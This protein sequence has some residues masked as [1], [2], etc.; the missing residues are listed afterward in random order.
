MNNNMNN[1]TELENEIRSHFIFHIIV[2]HSFPEFGIGIKNELPWNIKDELLH[3]KNVTS[4]NYY[5]TEERDTRSSLQEL[6]NILVFG[7]KTWE[8]I[9]EQGKKSI[10]KDRFVIVISSNINNHGNTSEYEIWSTW[11]DLITTLSY[12][13][14][15][16]KCSKHV[17]FAGGRTIYEQSI[18]NFPMSC[19]HITEIYMNKCSK[20][21]VFD[22]F[23]PYYNPFNLVIHNSYKLQVTNC[24]SFIC[25]NNIQTDKKIWYRYK[26]YASPYFI[27]Q[28]LHCINIPLYKV[29]EN[30]YLQIMREIMNDGID[31]N[32][33]TGTGTRAIFSSRQVYDLNDTFPIITTRRQWLKG[34]FEELK[35][36]I[37]GKTDN[38]ILQNK[39]IHIWDGNTSREFLDKRGLC[40]YPEGDMGET[41]GFNF[42]HFGGEYIDCNTNY[43]IGKYGYDQLQNVIHL[44]KYD[45]TSRRIIINLWNPS[46]LH[47][48]SLPSCLM[49]YQ[50][51]VDTQE[52]TL[53]CQ[54]YIRSSDYFLANNWNCCTGALLVHMLCALEDIPYTPGRI[55][56]IT[57]DTHIYKTHFE[58]VYENL[59]RVPVPFP[60][61]VINSDK[62]YSSINDIQYEDLWLIGYQS[63]P[64]ITAPMAI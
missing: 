21:D 48:A 56:V 32:D 5:S 11:D 33:R 40:H 58:Q 29:E 4:Y 6:R 64:S 28:Y 51:F 36:Y 15:T 43:E 17:F 24:S 13:K 3:F 41:Y 55:Y 49:M 10:L 9:S 1:N 18:H 26:T 12:L 39:N 60:K 16:N 25:N 54:I 7:R 23:F 30:N 35:L 22:R 31:R 50:F 59:T 38:T 47:K 2:A 45:P 14:E 27:D 19:A 63:Q 34:I 62:K 53:S 44:L 61:L 57:G 42:R 20:K 52:N 8:N 37:S 46:T